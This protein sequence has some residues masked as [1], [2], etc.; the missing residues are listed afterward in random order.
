MP[1]INICVYCGSN[2][3][4]NTAFLDAA[5]ELGIYIGK[6]NLN[7]IYGGARVGMMG[8]VANGALNH[9]AKVTGVLPRFLANE[10]EVPHLNLTELKLVDTMHERKHLMFSLSDAF[11]ILPGG[12]G[13]LEEFA[14]VITWLQLGSHNKPVCLLNIE[15]FYDPLLNLFSNMQR[16][17]FIHENLMDSLIIEN[18]IINAMEKLKHWEIKP[19]GKKWELDA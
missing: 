7:L 5:N 1:I 12:I 2:K 11:V 8:A 13:T 17:N 3:G 15:G 9:G 10:K 6:S 18:S 4:K 19:L 14:E 16:E